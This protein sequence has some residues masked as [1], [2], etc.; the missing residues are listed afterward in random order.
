[1]GKEG[2]RRVGVG[3]TVRAL[4][5]TVAESELT[6]LSLPPTEVIVSGEF[7]SEDEDEELDGLWSTI[8]V[9]ITLFLLSVCYSATVTLFKVKWF[10]SAMV[11]LKK[12]SGPEYKNV[13]QRVV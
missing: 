12:A 6:S 7:C 11:Q 2:D 13:I 10:F 1:M 9:F 5:V 4:S 3:R 8:S